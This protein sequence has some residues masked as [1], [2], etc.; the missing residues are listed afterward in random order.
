MKMGPQCSYICVIIGATYT[1]WLI[2]AMS[3]SQ[4][5]YFFYCDLEFSSF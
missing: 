3:F 4:V 1:C 2:A 5:L